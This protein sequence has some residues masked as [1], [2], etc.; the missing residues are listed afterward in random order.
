MLANY[1]VLHI[2]SAAGCFC[3]LL[4]NVRRDHAFH[5]V[6]SFFYFFLFLLNAVTAFELTALDPATAIFWFL[7]GRHLS[8][9]LPF[10]L[11]VMAA[12]ISGRKLFSAGGWA[13]GAL[14]IGL[15]LI[16]NV[17]FFTGGDPFI[18]PFR[19]FDFGNF[20]TVTAVGYI[21]LGTVHAVGFVISLYYLVV[22]R[23]W[24]SFWSPWFFI[25]LF[26][27]WWLAVFSTG[28]LTLLGFGIPPF[29]LA[30]DGML[31][32]AVCI[33]LTRNA[34]QPN[35]LLI[36]ASKLLTALS[37]GLVLS[38]LVLMSLADR[39]QVMALI[40]IACAG[41]LLFLET[42]HILQR[43]FLPSPRDPGL[44]PGLRELGLSPQEARICEL[45]HEGYS[46]QSLLLLLNISSGTLRNHLQNIYKKTL[47]A[48]PGGPGAGSRDKLQ[49]LTVFLHRRA[50]QFHDGRN[51]FLSQ[52]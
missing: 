25:P 22:P 2:V 5:R 34:L 49:Q 7:V 8:L 30:L 23:R 26:L 24:A 10:V 27:C 41:S 42:I 11:V 35:S 28:S 47:P 21:A 38:F 17:T 37:A 50:A 9:V 6:V 52:P 12:F 48:G 14:G 51:T 40:L 18:G 45:L 16:T 1:Y 20:V 46:R 29:G 44:V 39:V 13:V 15:I 43:K 3:L 31:S 4:D 19:Q 33:A 36:R 32:F